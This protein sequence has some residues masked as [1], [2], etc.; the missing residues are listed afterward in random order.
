MN[1][2][3]NYLLFLPLLI[4]LH[5]SAITAIWNGSL[6]SNSF[7]DENIQI[8]GNTT[9]ML[10]TTIVSASTHDI[11]ILV[12][13][14]AHV[15][16]NDSGQSTLILEA[17]YPWTITV[18]VHKNLEFGGVE[19]NLNIPLIILEQGDGS[20]NWVI[21]DNTSL[22]Y[23]SSDTRGGTLLTLYFDGLIL[24]KHTF[25]VH[26]DGK[27]KFER[28]AKIGYRILSS[29]SFTEYAIFDAVNPTD[30]HSTLV[31]YDDGATVL[32]Y[33]RKLILP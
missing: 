26:G 19:N 2:L 14:D 25:D 6:V 20:I 12:N 10:G 28:H 17:T 31:K 3:Y 23:G 33:Q 4:P 32:G 15:N 7:V 27:I 30:N 8:D 13:N 9:L 5:A 11:I 1:K 29:E 21:E 22:V 18:Q 24:P 16:S